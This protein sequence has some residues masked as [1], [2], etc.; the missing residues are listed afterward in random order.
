MFAGGPI[1][2]PLVSGIPGESPRITQWEEV[3]IIYTIKRNSS[4]WMRGAQ[5]EIRTIQ[6]ESNHPVEKY[7]KSI[8]P[9]RM[10]TY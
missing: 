7:I 8:H 2:R 4:C 3:T 1:G 6:C 9:I 10:E 5:A